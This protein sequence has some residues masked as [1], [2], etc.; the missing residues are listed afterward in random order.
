MTQVHYDR[1]SVTSHVTCCLW[2]THCTFTGRAGA[3]HTGLL[4]CQ[5]V[6][7]SDAMTTTVTAQGLPG[8]S[9]YRGLSVLHRRSTAQEGSARRE[10]AT[11]QGSQHPPA[12]GRAVLSSTDADQGQEGGSTKMY[13]VA[14]ATSL[15]RGQKSLCTTGPHKPLLP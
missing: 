6:L 13:K 1:T 9:A 15:I 14:I 5:G 4:R 7:H 12:S 3:A 11:P 8:L 2:H 10:E